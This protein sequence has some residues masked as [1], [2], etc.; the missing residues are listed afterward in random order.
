MK[1]KIMANVANLKKVRDVII[2]RKDN[3]SYKF[4]FSRCENGEE[5]EVWDLD[6]TSAGLNSIVGQVR[7]D[8][9]HNSCGTLGC[10]AGFC[11]ALSP[12]RKIS[13]PQDRAR[14]WL[15]LTPAEASWLFTPYSDDGFG[16]AQNHLRD[17]KCTKD[18]LS[19]ERCTQEEGFNE[20]VNRLN[21]LI[22]YYETFKA[23]FAFRGMP[24]FIYR[25]AKPFSITAL[26]RPDTREIAFNDCV[27]SPT[28]LLKL[29]QFLADCARHAAGEQVELKDVELI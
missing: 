8:L 10:V 12:D 9:L 4:I 11:L 23:T 5:E 14:I 20:A 29:S 2:S 13:S 3:F 21:Y 18:F 15:D 16:M 6:N 27:F 17:Y 24:L 19:F 26:K 22:D 25:A 7:D 1:E 28:D